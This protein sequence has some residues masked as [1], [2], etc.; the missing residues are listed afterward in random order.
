MITRALPDHEAYLVSLVTDGVPALL[1]KKYAIK[2]YLVGEVGW[3]IIF[4][5]DL[6]YIIISQRSPQ[7]VRKM[8]EYL[9]EEQLSENGFRICRV[10]KAE[11]STQYKVAV[12][13]E[14]DAH[15]LHQK[16]RHLKDTFPK[17]LYGSVYFIKFSNNTQ[18]Y[19]KNALLPA[20]TDDI[21]KVILREEIK[22]ADVYVDSTSV[23]LFFG[24]QGNNVASASKLTGYAIKIISVTDKPN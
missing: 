21:K 2:K 11:K 4:Q 22:Q 19:I 1:P 6:T 13:G 23:G 8:L 12:K 14:G 17:Y 16:T 7:Y 20:S 15:E 18:Q 3:A 9:L 24:K 5:T 10:A